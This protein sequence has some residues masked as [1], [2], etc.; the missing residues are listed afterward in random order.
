MCVAFVGKLDGLETSGRYAPE[1]S[2]IEIDLVVFVWKLDVVLLD[3]GPPVAKW[4]TRG[5]GGGEGNI[6]FIE[7]GWRCSGVSAV[8]LTDGIGECF[9][10]AGEF[11]IPFLFCVFYEVEDGVSTAWVDLEQAVWTES[12]RGVYWRWFWI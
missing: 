2:E 5:F 12:V 3:V 9:A 10:G 7:A 8:I 11:C 4:F 1:R 6:P